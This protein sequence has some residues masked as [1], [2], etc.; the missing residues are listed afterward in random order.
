MKQVYIDSCSHDLFGAFWSLYGTS[1]PIF[2]QRTLAQQKL[3]FDNGQQYRLL[4]FVED[5]EFLG[6]I[7]YW[8]F[9][10]YCYVEH[11]A[12]GATLR[13][14]G[15]GSRVLEKFMADVGKMV[16]LEIDPISDAVSEARWRFYKRCGF[17][18]N[19][20]QHK[21]SAYRVGYEPHSLVVLT[22]KRGITE[23]EYME[24]SRDLGEVVMKGTPDV[25]EK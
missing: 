4:A 7:S 20:Y 18:K 1:F 19:P 24:F 10:A 2:K 23:S 22:T 16:L 6:F 3:A 5:D 25:A 15:Y 13:G 9:D 14:K 8:E 11:F 21:H 12:I 17:F